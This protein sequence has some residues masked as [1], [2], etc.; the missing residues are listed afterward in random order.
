MSP[1]LLD[2]LG[3]TSFA[4]ELTWVPLVWTPEPGTMT[5]ILDYNRDDPR[6][7]SRKTRLSRFL[8]ICL[9]IPSLDSTS[10]ISL[11][12]AAGVRL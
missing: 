7:G 1:P 6:G 9:K 5:S 12:T 3:E 4:P 10:G 2:G 11:R 8:R